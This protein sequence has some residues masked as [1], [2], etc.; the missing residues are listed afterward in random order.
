MTSD[1]ITSAHQRVDVVDLRALEQV[2]ALAV[3]VDLDPAHVQDS[4][5]G[6]RRI[7]EHHPVAE[8]RATAGIDVDAQTD[9][10]VGL[11]LRQLRELADCSIRERDHS[12]RRRLHLDRR[13]LLLDHRA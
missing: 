10:R 12:G 5:L 4:I 1:T 8:A 2:H 11:F 6:R 3:D 13:R 7:L 9:G